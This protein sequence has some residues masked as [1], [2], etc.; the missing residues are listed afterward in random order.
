MQQI[1]FR[2]LGQFEV[3]VEGHALELKRR[4]QRALL[5]LLL[6]HAG[7][8]VST[9]RLTDELWAGAPPKTAVGS[10]Q[11]LISDV[12]KALGREVVQT[13]Q[14]G[15]VLD[16]A[17]EQ[18]DFHRFERL[19]AQASQGGDA[20]RRAELLREALGLWRGPPLS[21]LA[22]EA[23]ASVEIARL[24]ELRTAAHG[25]GRVLLIPGQQSVRNPLCRPRGR[26]CRGLQ[27][28]ARG[29]L[30]VRRDPRRR[31]GSLSCRER[32]ARAVAPFP[33]NH[34]ARKMGQDSMT[35][36]GQGSGAA[37]LTSHGWIGARGFSA[38]RQRCQHREQPRETEI[39]SIRARRATR[40]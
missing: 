17:P 35:R 9:D 31:R 27:L 2:V 39:R 30:T 25:P 14:P 4:K 40:A 22:F 21:D 36:S 29:P 11:N 37:V 26:P 5:A 18:V 20:E 1:E 19:V 13:R 16:V 15:Y 6:L 12:R 24:E 7:E 32:G 34:A 8:V 10:L 38:L 28:D 3:L 33:D 23:F